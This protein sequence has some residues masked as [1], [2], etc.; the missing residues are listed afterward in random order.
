MKFYLAGQNNFGNRGCEALVRSTYHLIS[1]VYPEATLLVPSFKKEL[2]EQQWKLRP[3]ESIQFINT[4]DTPKEL[5]IWNKVIQKMPF[6]KRLIKPDYF[7]P[8][9]IKQDID[10]VDA[11]I[12]T[13]GDVI[14]LEYG[15]PSLFQWSGLMDKASAKRVPTIL[16]AASVG[17]FSADPVVEQYMIRHLKNYSVITVRETESFN[18]LQGL[19]LTNVELVADPAFVMVPEEFDVSSILPPIL[20]EGLLGFNVSPLIAKFRKSEAD[21]NQ[22]LEEVVHFIKNV[23]DT[24]SLSI[25]L[26]PHVDPLNGSEKNSDSAYMKR[27]LEKLGGSSS[28]LTMAPPTLNAAQLKFL[29]SKCRFFIGA[30]TH[31]TIGALS[32]LVPTLSIAYSVKAKGLNKDLF[33]NTKYVLNTPDVSK[34]TL[35]D[36]L[37]LLIKD[38]QRIRNLLSEKIPVWREKSAISAKAL[39][40]I[41]I[42]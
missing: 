3:Q 9:H 32:M 41:L 15:L 7:L 31:A 19:G 40:Q 1:Q 2:D 24:T 12:M 33:G 13:G 42:K 25:M 35:I 18:Y 5:I 4:F 23:L 26:I 6:L 17:P 20:G 29:L 28:R 38:E 39:S 14:S 8:S 16:W 30:R 11:V 10:N 34:S 27:L 21:A 22:M 36:G 37:N